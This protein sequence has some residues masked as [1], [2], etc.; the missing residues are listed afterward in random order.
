MEC[1]G[2]QFDMREHEL[3]GVMIDECKRCGGVWLDAGEAEELV[4]KAPTPREALQKKKLELLRQWQVAALNPRET[5]RKCPRCPEPLMRVNYKDIPG[6]QIDKC[7]SD[8][9]MY[10]DKGELEKVRLID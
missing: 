1:P 10:L 2:C 7:R 4:K 9:G 8:C 6:L 3:D 5:D